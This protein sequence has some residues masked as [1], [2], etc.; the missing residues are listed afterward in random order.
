MPHFT[1]WDAEWF[2][3]INS[4]YR[5]FFHRNRLL[6]WSSDGWIPAL[7]SDRYFWSVF[8]VN[9]FG[10]DEC[11]RLRRLGFQ[12]WNDTMHLADIRNVDAVLYHEEDDGRWNEL[13]YLRHASDL[14]L[15][16]LTMDEMISL[17]RPYSNLI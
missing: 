9:E 11:D 15:P 5:K 6:D 1:G 4:R 16:I 12:V 13:S 17:T 10:G 14:G 3:E 2:R 8:T 7:K